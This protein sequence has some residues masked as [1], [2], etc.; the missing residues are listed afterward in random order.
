M[1]KA[2]AR[3]NG[4]DRDRV[5]GHRVGGRARSVG[6]G[7]EGGREKIGRREKRIKYSNQHICLKGKFYLLTPSL[8][9]S[10]SLFHPPPPGKTVL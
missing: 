9:L 4:E 1:V 8:S 5:R 10:F 2:A 6:G 3:L 7:R